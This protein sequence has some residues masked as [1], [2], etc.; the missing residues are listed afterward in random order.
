MQCI[1]YSSLLQIRFLFGL[2]AS[3]KVV[4]L[5]TKVMRMLRKDNI[6]KFCHV[7]QTGL[8]LYK[9]LIQPTCC[10]H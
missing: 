10:L 9:K 4:V 2:G 5:V 1:W 7:N 3:G 6:F 8:T